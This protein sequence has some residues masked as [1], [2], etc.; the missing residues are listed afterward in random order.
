[1]L[2]TDSVDAQLGDGLPAEVVLGLPRATIDEA[3]SA[4]VL[5]LLAPDLR[6]E[7]PVLF[8]RLREAAV[9]R[10]VPVIELSALPTAMTRYATASLTY[11]PG[12]VAALARA[13]VAPESSA[14][15]EL[16]TARGI[17]RGAS[18]ADGSGVVVVLGRPSVAE[19]H[20][21]VDEAAAALFGAWPEA[22]FLPALR[23]SNVHGALDMGLAPGILPGR[24][25]LDEGRG[26]YAAAWGTLPEER[27]LD[28]AGMLAAAAEQRVE[29]LVLLGADPLS[30]FPDRQLAK[31][32][33]AARPS[34]SPSTPS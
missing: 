15:S 3:C 13:L 30:D 26:W 22:R 1:V 4:D 23:R 19:A 32:G 6:E 16:E 2:G 17:I 20:D 9:E 18:G 33:M 31:R 21:M 25:S 8:L 10:G 5:V 28:T 11:R 29:A 7:L 24:V 14:D 12:E 27:G 34:S